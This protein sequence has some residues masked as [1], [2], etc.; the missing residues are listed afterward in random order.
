A[1]LRR[2]DG[3]H[4]AD[5]VE[6]PESRL[7]LPHRSRGHAARRA[8]HSR[9]WGAV[10][11]WAVLQLQW[12]SG[13]PA[14]TG[15]RRRGRLAARYPDRRFRLELSCAARRVALRLPAR[16]RLPVGAAGGDARLSDPAVALGE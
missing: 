13:D 9:A 1:F 2:S 7:Q 11:G 4:G 5:A 10:A 8:F 14:A 16:A 6:L 12:D 15:D 3:R